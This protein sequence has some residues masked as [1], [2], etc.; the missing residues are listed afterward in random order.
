MRRVLS[1]LIEEADTGKRVDLFLRSR[2]FSHHILTQLKRTDSGL[3][4][5]GSRCLVSALLQKGDLLTVTL[6]GPVPSQNV[7]PVFLPLSMVYED[8]DLC[9]L[10]K[11]AGM[12]VHPS[13][14]NHE[15]TLANGLAWYFK[16]QNLPYVCRFINRLDRDTTGLLIAAKHAL[17]AS[18]LSDMLKKREIHR[19]YLALVKG[20]T[21]ASGTISA[22]IARLPDSALKRCVDFS[23]GE[24]AV[25]HFTTL[26]YRPDRYENG[27]SLIS[28]YLETGR[29]HQIRVHMN[30]IGHPLPGDFLYCPDNTFIQRQALH[31]YRLSFAHPITGEALSFTSPLPEDMRH[32]FYD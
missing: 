22:P 23:H 30:F 4:L 7:L 31:S 6:E 10:D 3:L 12:P 17:S 20:K 8:E 26:D 27:C 25:T 11:P 2:G 5:N 14:N 28:L 21:P 15:N 16:E 19:E 29:T 9:V 18:I 32:A 1:Y 13:I 24:K